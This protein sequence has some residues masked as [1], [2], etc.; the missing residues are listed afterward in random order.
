M[1]VISFKTNI[2]ITAELCTENVDYYL[3]LKNKLD[4]GIPNELIGHATT[5]RINTQDLR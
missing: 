5:Y 3:I 4:S 1:F 2:F